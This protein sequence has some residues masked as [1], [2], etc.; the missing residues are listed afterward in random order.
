[1]EA[2]LPVANRD[3]LVSQAVDAGIRDYIQSRRGSVDEFVDKHFSFRGALEL[4]RRAFGYDLLRAPAN[5]AWTPL[6]FL[7]KGVGKG[8]QHVGLTS[9]SDKLSDLPAGIRTD[10]EKEIQWRIYT[11]FLQL[12]FEQDDRASQHNA[13][14]DSILSQPVLRPV[15][16][17]SLTRLAKLANDEAGKAS[18]TENLSTYVNSRKVAA[19]LSAILVGAAAGYTANQTFNVGALGLGQ[20]FATTLAY[21]SAVS[22][23]ALGNTLG[24]LYYTVVPVT[25]SK[26]ALVLSTGGAA[27][28]LGVVAAFAGVVADPLQKQLGLHQKKLNKLVDCLEG[29]L[30]MEDDEA[31]PVREAYIARVLDLADVLLTLSSVR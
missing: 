3:T 14:L 2:Q 23:F 15:F 9:V 7:L 31:L 16:E 24:G 4:N 6:H 8:A 22:S 1:M 17:E 30:V 20:T 28:L 19:E 26:S 10:I 13:L 18:L 5:L 11:E 12:P 27:A 25:V 29:Q 21:H